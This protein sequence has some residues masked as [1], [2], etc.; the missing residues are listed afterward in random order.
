[1]G[2]FGRENSSGTECAEREA[3]SGSKASHIRIFRDRQSPTTK[4][5]ITKMT[6]AEAEAEVEDEGEEVEEEEEEVEKE[7][8]ENR[9]SIIHTEIK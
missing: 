9:F 3:R 2:S 7:K 5:M 6:E 4:M 8:E 1:M